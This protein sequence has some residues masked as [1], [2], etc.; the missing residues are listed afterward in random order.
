[1]T[2]SRLLAAALEAEWLKFR[3]APVPWMA[4]AALV[5]GIAAL[6]SSFVLVAGQ[7]DSLMAAKLDALVV[8]TGWT[9]LVSLASQITAVGGLLGFGVVLAWMFGREFADGVIAGL[10]ALPVRRGTIAAAK[11]LVYAGWALALSMALVGVI[12]GIGLALGFGAPTSAEAGTMARLFAI[13]LLTAGLALPC[14]IV[15]TI[16]RGYLAPIGAVIALVAIAQIAVVIGAGGW[17]PWAAP[18]LWAGLSGADAT[19]RVTM[20]QLLLVVSVA[21]ASVHLT[22]RAWARLQL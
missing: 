8:G 11:L 9:A 7:P 10:F 3:S 19:S 21:A 16:A 2:R 5:M 17:F 4:T 13:A 1:M 15:A 22:T 20:V 6:C 18:G 12:F 14:A